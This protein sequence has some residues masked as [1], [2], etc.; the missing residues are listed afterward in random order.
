MF[1]RVESWEEGNKCFPPISHWFYAYTYLCNAI[2]VIWVSI[3][4]C[5]TFS[6][7]LLWVADLLQG[8]FSG[9][10]VS[11]NMSWLGF[12]WNKP[13]LPC[14]LPGP[15]GSAPSLHLDGFL[16]PHP[17]KPLTVQW[18]WRCREK[19]TGGGTDRSLF[20]SGCCCVQAV[21]FCARYSTMLASLSSP[22]K[23][24]DAPPPL[25][26]LSCGW[27][28]MM[29]VNLFR[30]QNSSPFSVLGWVWGLFRCCI[31]SVFNSLNAHL[32][33][34]VLKLTWAPV[35]EKID[36]VSQA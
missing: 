10:H 6:K 35:G 4:V 21:R 19:N 13:C 1:L 3:W 12:L 22:G 2:K 26:E 16:L 29:N 34:M 18:S 17:L 5:T 14:S 36:Q 25:P 32:L 24:G 15:A 28:Q 11:V 7:H 27:E 30:V 33:Y 23:W 9:F 31:Y 20:K 8:D